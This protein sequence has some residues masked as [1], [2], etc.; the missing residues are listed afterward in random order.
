MVRFDD[1]VDAVSTLALMQQL[2]QANPDIPEI[3]VICDNASY[4]NR[5][6][7]PTT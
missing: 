2:E 3:I 7:L 5:K 4:Y 6:Q 1:T